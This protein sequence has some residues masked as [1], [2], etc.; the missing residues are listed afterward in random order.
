[1]SGPSNISNGNG[2][3]ARH[4]IPFSSSVGILFYLADATPVNESHGA[5]ACCIGVQLT[6]L[7]SG[8]GHVATIYIRSLYNVT[9]RYNAAVSRHFVNSNPSIR[10]KENC[11]GEN[12]RS[13]NGTFSTTVLESMAGHILDHDI[14]TTGGLSPQKYVLSWEYKEY[15]PDFACGCRSPRTTVIDNTTTS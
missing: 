3:G 2:T 5:R 6:N 15:A 7:T 1:M 9:V 8:Q 13:S 14:L 12:E 11:M 10:W 4:R